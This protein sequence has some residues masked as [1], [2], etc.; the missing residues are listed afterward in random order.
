MSTASATYPQ[1]VTLKGQFT[2]LVPLSLDHAD[3]LF[4]G[5]GGMGNA[6]I[7][8]YVSVGPFVEREAFQDHIATMI[9]L[10]DFLAFVILDNMTGRATGCVA[11]MAIDTANRKV[12]VGHVTFSSKLQRTRGA[13]E[14]MYLL[15]RTV[16]EDWA[17]RRYEWE[18]NDLN[19]AS[20][21]AA[22]RLGFTW[23][24]LFRQHRI[25]KGRNRDTAQ[26]SMLDSEWPEVKRGLEAWLEPGNFDELGQQR[27]SLMS[28]RGPMG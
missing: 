4:E 19:A 2:T 28:L 10:K 15:A 24:G 22:Q 16:F 13:T 9:T 7:W 3:D 20:K 26:Y 27:S 8:D 17:Y 6:A 18:C 23:E 5:L 21:H 12:E 25:V 14:C 1:R 11:L